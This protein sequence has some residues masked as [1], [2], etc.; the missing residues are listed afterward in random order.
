MS[1]SRAEPRKE[2]SRAER[3]GAEQGSAEARR[4]AHTGRKQGDEAGGRRWRSEEAVAQQRGLTVIFACEG[5]D[6]L[7]RHRVQTTSR[8]CRLERPAFGEHLA[9]RRPVAGGEQLGLTLAER[10][11]VGEVTDPAAEAGMAEGVIAAVEGGQAI[12]VDGCFQRRLGADWT[13][14]RE[15]LLQIRWK[16]VEAG[17]RLRGGGG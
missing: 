3:S 12:A 11:G 15:I 8:L 4:G 1:Q 10:A 7:L 2:R 16:R 14:L 9:A 13:V 6:L 17:R 5:L